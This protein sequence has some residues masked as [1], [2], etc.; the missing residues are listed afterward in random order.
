MSKKPSLTCVHGFIQGRAV[1]IDESD[2]E[3]KLIPGRHIR[4]R[5]TDVVAYVSGEPGTLEVWMAKIV[6]SLE[7]LD[8]QIIGTIEEMDKAMARSALRET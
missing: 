6:P 7:E 8:F 5:A 3:P 2:G 1:G 4:L